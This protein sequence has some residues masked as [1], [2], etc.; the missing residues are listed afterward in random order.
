M[1]RGIDVRLSVPIRQRRTETHGRDGAD[2][3]RDVVGHD[4]SSRRIIDELRL[5]GVCV[6]HEERSGEIR[7][8][9]KRL[10]KMSAKPLG[11]RMDPGCTSWNCTYFDGDLALMMGHTSRL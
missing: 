7:G 4:G 11:L 6:G 10:P 2:S 1:L 5:R 8:S 3:H 9:S